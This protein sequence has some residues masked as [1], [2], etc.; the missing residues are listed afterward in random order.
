ML[1]ALAVAAP[2]AQA[3]LN[4][5]P[6]QDL[7]PDGTNSDH[8]GLAIDAQGGAIAVWLEPDSG[9]GHT[10]VAAAI[11]PAG[12]NFGPPTFVSE[13]DTD[14]SLPGVAMNRPGDAMV[15]WQRVRPSSSSTEV[16]YAVRP[17]GGSFGA[18]RSASFGGGS[19][20][21][22]HAALDDQGN[23]VIAYIR[24]DGIQPSPRLHAAFRPAGATTDFSSP[25]TIS[26]TFA[27]GD[28]NVFAEDPRVAMDRDGNALVSWT[29]IYNSS[30]DPELRVEAAYRPA[31]GTNAAHFQTKQTLSAP[32]TIPNGNPDGNAANSFPAFDRSGN[33]MVVF[34]RYGGDY[35]VQAAFRPKVQGSFDA[36]KTLSPSG[37]ETSA[38]EV[39]FD[40]SGNAFAA[41]SQST[42]ATTSPPYRIQSAFRPVGG[43][44]GAPQLVSTTDMHATEAHIGVDGAG[45]PAILW[46][47]QDSNGDELVQ[48]TSRAAGDGPFAAPS[49][50]SVKGEL[51]PYPGQGTRL[52]VSDAGQSVGLWSR[53]NGGNLIA[54]AAVGTPAAELPPPPPPPPPPPI[55]S[56]IHPA[57]PFE[58][59][60][61]IVLTVDVS[62]PVD[63]LQWDFGRASP[64]IT[65][66]VVDGRLQRSVRLR[67]TDR[68]FTATVKAIGPGG[69]T[70]SSRSFLAPKPLND[71]NTQRVEA[72]MSTANSEPVVAVGD[73]STL[74][75][76]AKTATGAASRCGVMTV[77]SG[78]QE[79]TGCMRPAVSMPDIPDAERG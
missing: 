64:G 48:A 59:G 25:Q 11:R 60:K 45:R 33:A 70:T 3:D 9:S 27:P 42:S 39:A 21:D 46:T 16:E 76:N 1:L 29:S 50:L 28:T 75:G 61:A 74:V 63:R 72:G 20:L 10:R 62:G 67:P 66:T 79:I 18:P 17:A 26:Q 53:S 51:A 13:P 19:A 31:G 68:S 77:V 55:P 78:K 2:A 22:G 23:A 30:T 8:V 43:D 73:E 12:G 36:A 34:T 6:A 49:N 54:Q 4:W 65:G 14:A 38:P 24:D 71:A 32:G 37:V 41:W 44:F 47:A 35:R 57:K 7:S 69:T 5:S 40:P 15:T 56:A 52:A 58:R